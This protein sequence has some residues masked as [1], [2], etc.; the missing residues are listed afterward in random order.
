MLFTGPRKTLSFLMQMLGL[1]SSFS[2]IIDALRIE[3]LVKPWYVCPEFWGDV[4]QL[5]T[6]MNVDVDNTFKRYTDRGIQSADQLVEAFITEHRGVQYIT[7]QLLSCRAYLDVSIPFAERNLYVLASRIPLSVK[8]HN[9][10]N[11]DLLRKYSPKLLQFRTAA[12]PVPASMPV[13]VQEISRLI[14]H[15]AEKRANMPTIAWY[16]W[17]FLRN[18]KVLY[19]IV[20]D[21]KAD[22]WNMEAIR[23]RIEE[24]HKNEL[25]PVGRLFQRLLIMYTVDLMLR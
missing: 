6:T 20:D 19:D 23:Q 25:E 16:D 11:R 14:R 3:H 8:F 5:L 17:E 9:A 24:L 13:L 10:L 2:S 22:L 12:A 1:N 7:S 18:D 21:L 15:T 4:D